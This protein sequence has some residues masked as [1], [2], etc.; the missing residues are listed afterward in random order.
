M[1]A[2]EICHDLAVPKS[3]NAI[4]LVLQELGPLGLPAR[5]AIVLTAINFHDQPSLVANK[6]GNVAADRHLAAELVPF[7]LARARP[8]APSTGCFFIFYL[9]GGRT[10]PPPNLPNQGGGLRGEGTPCSAL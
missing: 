4:A 5:R 3:Q 6:I 10:S 9:C 2:V 1:D 7:H 8:C